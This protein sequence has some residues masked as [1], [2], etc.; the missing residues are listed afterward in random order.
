MIRTAMEGR[1]ATVYA[2]REKIVGH[3]PPARS[4]RD[5]GQHNE[6]KTTEVNNANKNANNTSCVDAITAYLLAVN[7]FVSRKGEVEVN[8]LVCLSTPK[9]WEC[10]R[11]RAEERQQ[12]KNANVRTQTSH[13]K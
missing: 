2:G 9:F 7:L 1:P 6:T 5:R 12:R 11:G 3:Q 8:P 10:R 13:A 4:R